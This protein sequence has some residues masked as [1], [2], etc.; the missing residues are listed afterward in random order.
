MKGQPK[1]Y[2]EM[3]V[4]LTSEQ[5]KNVHLIAGRLGLSHPSVGENNDRRIII[6]RTNFDDVIKI[7]SIPNFFKDCSV[8]RCTLSQG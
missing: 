6:S 3:P 7:K 5:R 8:E 4:W 1:E 2:L